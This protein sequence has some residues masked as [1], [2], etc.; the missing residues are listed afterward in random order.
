MTRWVL[1]SLTVLAAA[2]AL[3][4]GELG[5]QAP[6]LSISEWVKGEPVD[7]SKADGKHFYVVEFWATW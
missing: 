2:G 5:S 6:A 7:V 1:A 3:Q 4:A